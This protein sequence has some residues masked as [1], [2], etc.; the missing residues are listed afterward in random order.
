MIGLDLVPATSPIAILACDL[1]REA[2]IQEAVSDAAAKL[3]G[4]DLLVNNAGI[5][6][7]APLSA[8]TADEIDRHFRR[9]CE[10]RHPRHARAL[11]H[12]GDGARI[13]N[14]ASELAYLGRANA[15]VNCASKAAVLG[16]TRSWA[17]E[18]APRNPGQ[19]RSPRPHRYAAAR[20]STA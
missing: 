17:R 1:M 9:Q 20:P 6:R 18:L 2:D 16:L 7:E 12:M 3:G 19:R 14:I 4:I 11:V 13:V 15:S 5:M 10:G 8:I